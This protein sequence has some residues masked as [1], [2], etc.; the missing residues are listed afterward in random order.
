MRSTDWDPSQP[1]AKAFRDDIADRITGFLDGQQTVVTDIAD[2]LAPV[3]ELARAFTA[4]GK[5]IRP[6]F[7][8]W[9]Y[10]AAADRPAPE[11]VRTAAASLDLLHVSALVHDDVM[12]DSDLRRGIPAAHHQFATRHHDHAGVGDADAF[13]RAG[14]ILLGDMLVMWSVEMLETAGLDAAELARARPLLAAMRTEVTAGQFL[15][16]MAQAQLRTR[17]PEDGDTLQA[18]LTEASRVV[19]YKTARYTVQRPVQFGAALGGGSPEL[20]EALARFGS[21]IGRAFQ[22][23]DDLLGVFGTEV[24]TG[25]PAGG[26]LREGKRT[27]LL[28]QTAA[29][30]DDAGRQLLAELVGRD[31]MT[32]AD[33]DR[34]RQVITDSGAADRVEA[35]IDR[36]YDE[37]LSHLA[38]APAGEAGRTA[39]SALATAAVRRD[40]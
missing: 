4:G 10:V 1:L 13:G 30:T 15:D 5:R 9:G 22:Y 31:R 21:A 6:A 32:D 14:A 33:L 3:V 40:T 39:L 38:D 19:E 26:D 23:R 25:K 7:A 12:D 8:V 16:V 17:G 36:L 18:A 2:E 34:L 20:L 29:G 27:V 28:A 37:A 35:M 11:A 24:V